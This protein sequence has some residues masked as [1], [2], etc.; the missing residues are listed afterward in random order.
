MNA[1]GVS[2]AER[3]QK[4]LTSRQDWL[5]SSRRSGWQFTT[6]WLTI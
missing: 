5:G 6:N 1:N 2:A 3:W 4:C